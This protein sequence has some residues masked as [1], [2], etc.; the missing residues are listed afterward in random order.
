MLCLTDEADETCRTNIWIYC[1]VFR[2]N[3]CSIDTVSTC[4]W[5][6]LA[7]KPLALYS[8]LRFDSSTS[9]MFTRLNFL[10]L[11]SLKNKIIFS[12]DLLKVAKNTTALVNELKY[13]IKYPQNKVKL[14]Q[15]LSGCPTLLETLCK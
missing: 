13:V 5:S 12:F 15:D 11:L 8:H 7:A 4:Y 14:S 6:L 2:N 10:K 9:T 1:S 3:W